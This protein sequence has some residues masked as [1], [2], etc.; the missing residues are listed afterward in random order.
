MNPYI[1]KLK[2]CLAEE[3]EYGDGEE[4]SPLEVLYLIYTEFHT[5]DTPAIRE[6]FARLSRC[7]RGLP[8]AQDDEISYIVCDLCTQHERAAFYEGL[9]VGARLASELK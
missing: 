8:L 3:P 7:T 4:S 9:R 1:E 6:S 5:K 2:A